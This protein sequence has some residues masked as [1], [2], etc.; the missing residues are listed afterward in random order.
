MTP[1][2]VAVAHGSRDPRS[3]ETVRALVDVVRAQAP[4]LS[5][6]ES[7]LDLSEPRVTDVLRKFLS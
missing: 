3:A 2:L 4:G 7:F 1:P 6:Y 5:V